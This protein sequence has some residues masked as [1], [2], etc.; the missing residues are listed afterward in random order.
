MK[1]T[2]SVGSPSSGMSYTRTNRNYDV[3]KL[4]AENRY[5]S[6]N[7]LYYVLNAS[8]LRGGTY[9]GNDCSSFISAAIWGM[10][11]AHSSDRINVIAKTSAYKTVNSTLDLRSGDLL[12]RSSSHVVMFLYYANAAK[13][14]MMLIEQGGGGDELGIGRAFGRAVIRPIGKGREIS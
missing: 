10:N 2:Q 7:G 13:T 9:W 8:N 14:Q 5:L 1:R 12:N 4:L 6:A 11:S 3:D